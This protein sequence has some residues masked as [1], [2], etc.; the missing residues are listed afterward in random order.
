VS[1]IAVYGQALFRGFPF[2]AF[3]RDIWLICLSNVIGAFGEGLYL[4]VFPLYIKTLQA[5]YVQ[6]GLVFSALYG[7][8]A[9][10]PLLGG[11]LAD[12]FDRKKILILAWVPWACAPLIY[13]F[14]SEWQQLIPGAVC[15]G[16]SM[17]GVPAFNAYII[18]STVDKAKTASVLSFVWSS[19]SFSYIFAPTV[20]GYLATIM[21]MRLVLCAS[22]LLTAVATAVFF[23][24]HS[25]HPLASGV[26]DDGQ[27]V[28]S[29]KR[30]MQWRRMLL[31]SIYFALTTFF[32]TVGRTF[33][34]TFLSEQVGFSE[35]HVA[36]FGSVGFAGMTVIGITMGHL[37]D[38]WRKSR[39]I[40]LCLSLFLVSTLS[41]FLVREVAVLM[42]VAF[43]F[44]GSGVTGAL[45]SSFIGSIAPENKRGLWLSV[46]QTLSLTAAFIAPYLAGFLYTL[47]PNNTFMFSI[48]AMPF[49]ILF[50]LAG[51][52]E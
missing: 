16:I 39:A 44:G 15:W 10:T 31:W 28:S 47:D 49:L 18:T 38:R 12:R 45:V 9:L 24:I 20:G 14:A 33:V 50:A 7:V 46:P 43:F 32:M 41:L 5:D 37:G 52:K 35:F 11:V 19:Y 6:I 27:S 25:Q 29:D 23:F 51:L 22:A 13:S 30:K 8:S 48:T 21:G 4:Y 26:K 34:P 2:K 17:I 40:G 1:K 42:L 3:T 36:L